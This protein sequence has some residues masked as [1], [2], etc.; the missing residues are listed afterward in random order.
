MDNTKS[1]YKLMEKYM[2]AALIV[3]AILFIFYVI[4]AGCGIIWLKII[5]AIIL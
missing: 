4:T 5:L 3:A 2:T 1:R